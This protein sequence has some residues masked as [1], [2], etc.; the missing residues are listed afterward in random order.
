MTVVK[1][2]LEL[3]DAARKCEPSLSKLQLLS[4]APALR[5]NTLG[6]T[7]ALSKQERNQQHALSYTRSHRGHLLRTNYW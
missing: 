5:Q 1:M 6:P 7:L 4:F 3:S 2:G